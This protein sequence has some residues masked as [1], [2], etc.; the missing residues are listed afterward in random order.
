M[1][2]KGKYDSPWKATLQGIKDRNRTEGEAVQLPDTFD[3]SD[4]TVFITGASAGLGW[5]TAVRC[6]AAGCK[7]IIANRSG[8]PE[9]VNELQEITGNSQISGYK[10]DLSD[11]D[12]VRDLPARLAAD[13]ISIDILISNAAMVPLKARKTRQGLEEMFV[14]NYLAPFYMIRELIAQQV[15]V[16]SGKVIIVSSESHRNAQD[17]DWASFGTF[18]PYSMKQ[19]VGRYGYFKLFLTAFAKELSRRTGH[20]VRSLCPGPVNSSIAREAPGW[21]QPLLKM[22]FSLFFR[23]PEKASDPVMYF[24]SEDSAEKA[25][26][27]LFLMRRKEID[28]KAIDEAN[29]QRLWKESEALLTSLD[30]PLTP[31]K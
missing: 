4:K 1:S 7:L 8:F 26:D 20:P 13:G 31:M 3:L 16:E 11:L 2:K 15:L 12:Q 14:V 10:V 6:A 21:M 22:A 24:V 23:S 25:F 28:E 5:A 27:Y 9:K 29:G 17:I 19:T 18:E 30:Y